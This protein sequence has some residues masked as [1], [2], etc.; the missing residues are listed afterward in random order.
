MSPKFGI[1]ELPRRVE[2]AVAYAKLAEDVGFDFIGVADSQSLFRDVYVTAG[3]IASQTR[4]IMIGPSVTNPVTRH[5]AVSASAI[6][7]VNEISAGRCILGIGS[8]DS[9]ILNLGEKPYNLAGLR[10]VIL[11]LKQLLNGQNAEWQGHEIHTQWVD[12]PVPV[13]L[14]AEGPKTLELAGEVADGVIC[15]MGLTPDVVKLSLRHVQIGAERA[16]RSLDD[17]DIWA[18]TRI[19]IGDQRDRLIREIRM[20]LASTA[21][22]AF[23]F[24]LEGKQV[25]PAFIDTIRRV[26]Q[27]YQTRRHEMLGE[28]PNAQLMQ[29]PEF[30]EY[31]VQRFAV[32]GTPTECVEQ[33]KRIIRAG[34]TNFLFTGFVPDRDRLIRTLGDA[35]LPL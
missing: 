25:P 32:L 27:G 24:T 11:A 3:M 2:S 29:D 13:Y 20:E 31:M 9:A 16:G 15:G 33:L 10:D 26:Q 7:T 28:S 5:P 14:A 30:L 19:N 34:F 1:I 35:V 12:R 21:H 6:A 18:M 23:R 22:H 4:R 17:L 8:G